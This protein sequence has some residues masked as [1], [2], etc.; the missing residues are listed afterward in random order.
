MAT[1]GRG[2]GV[3]DA[4]AFDQAPWWDDVR[5][6]TV[7]APELLVDWATLELRGPDAQHFL[8][9][10][11][12]LWQLEARRSGDDAT[13]HA[14]LFGE[15]TTNGQQMAHGG[16]TSA[17]FDYALSTAGEIIVGAEHVTASLTMKFRRPVPAPA[18]HQLRTRTFPGPR[19]SSRVTGELLDADGQ[20]LRCPRIDPQ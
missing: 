5:A 20:V 3:I 14:V 10:R 1:N 4:A 2:I 12:E 13:A 17:L 8:M 16:A 19:R 6:A 7:P 15:H 9:R 18:L 11:P